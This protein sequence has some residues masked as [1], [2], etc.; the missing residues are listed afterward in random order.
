MFFFQSASVLLSVGWVR[1]RYRPIFSIRSWKMTSWGQ[2]LPSPFSQD[3]IGTVCGLWRRPFFLSFFLS[4][5]RQL[6]Y[7][8]PIFPDLRPHRRKTTWNP[9]NRNWSVYLYVVSA[10]W[11]CFS[12]TNLRY[13][14][15][16][17]CSSSRQLI[18]LIDWQPLAGGAGPH[19]WAFCR[20]YYY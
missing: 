15:L 7:L 20:K 9:L 8:L 3:L 12:S 4:L 17:W 16:S 18:H 14:L 13:W 19:R 10:H 6:S 1:W 5:Q 2:Q 11:F